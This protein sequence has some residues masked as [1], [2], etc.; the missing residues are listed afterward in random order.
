MIQWQCR[1]CG[2]GIEV[3]E[4]HATEAIECPQCGVFSRPPEELIPKI[5]TAPEVESVPP[6]SKFAKYQGEPENSSDQSEHELPV[7]PIVRSLRLTNFVS[8]WGIV[9]I[10]IGVVLC[11][12]AAAMPTTYGNTHNLGLLNNRLVMAVLSSTVFLCGTI[13]WGIGSCSRAIVQANLVDDDQS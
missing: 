6:R 12:I 1:Q 3:P 11:I 8:N 7:P 2:E 4:S 5:T 9:L 13:L 10:L